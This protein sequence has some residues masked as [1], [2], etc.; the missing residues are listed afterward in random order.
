MNLFV[1]DANPRRAARMMCD[2]HVVKMCLETA[3]LLCT[4]VNEHGG[5]A[6]YKTTHKNPPCAVWTRHSWVNFLWVFNHGKAL[7]AEYTKRYGRKHK[8]EDVIEE[9]ARLAV[10]STLPE[11]FGTGVWELGGP[12]QCMPDEYKDRSIVTAY[13]NYYI[14]EKSYLAKWN[15]GTPAPSWWPNV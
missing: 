12:P 7:C 13:R 5:S 3:Q 6:P 2:K 9:C 8:C 11:G 10:T 4:A 1:L 14:G 15:K